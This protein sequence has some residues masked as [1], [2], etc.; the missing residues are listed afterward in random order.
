VQKFTEEIPFLQ[1]K[2]LYF[3][4]IVEVAPERTLALEKLVF[5]SGQQPLRRMSKEDGL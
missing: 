3:L 4:R 1:S 5:E 2:V